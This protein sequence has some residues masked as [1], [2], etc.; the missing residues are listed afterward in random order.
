[1]VFFSLFALFVS[2]AEQLQR[3]HHAG[4]GALKE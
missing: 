4:R 3:N 1:M 2:S